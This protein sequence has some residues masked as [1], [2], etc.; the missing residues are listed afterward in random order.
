MFE[1]EMRRINGKQ[2]EPVTIPCKPTSPNVELKLID[3]NG[4]SIGS[5]YDPYNGF[6]VVFNESMHDKVITCEA[7][8]LMM[9]KK[10]NVIK[11]RKNFV[12]S[13]GEKCS[14]I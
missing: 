10:N 7:Q 13:I 9:D 4:T 8:L 2:Y 12:T 14:D 6:T 3:E 5:E 1:P 11:D